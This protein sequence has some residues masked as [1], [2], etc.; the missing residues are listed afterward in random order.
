MADHVEGLVRSGERRSHEVAAVAAQLRAEHEITLSLDQERSRQGGLELLTATHPLSRAAVGTPGYRQGRFTMLRMS[1]DTAG[2]EPGDYLTLLTVVAWDGLR[3]LHEVWSSSV[4]LMTLADAGDSIGVAVMKELARANL[5]PGESEAAR[6][7]DL[8]FAVEQATVNLELR[9]AARQ[10]ELRRENAAFLEMRRVSFDQVHHR[11]MR[12]L[13]EALR[14]NIER[15]NT[16]IIPASRA[17]IAKQEARYST[18]L[19]GLDGKR[20]PSLSRN[21]LAVCVI[22]VH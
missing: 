9:A 17:R 13:H 19:S 21:D 7:V 18:Q 2:V 6:G 20:S 10:A 11:R 1:A 15:G 16:R 3:P 5:C 22:E 14:T 8:A 12:R 4:H